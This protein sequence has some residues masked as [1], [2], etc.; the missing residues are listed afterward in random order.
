MDIW[1]NVLSDLKKNY[2]RELHGYYNKQEAEQLL[3]ILIEHFFAITRYE[4]ILKPDYRLSESEIL[5]LHMAVK[6]LKKYKPVQ[7]IT[8]MVEFHDLKFMVN[9][10]VL[11]PRPETEE[12]VQLI[13]NIENKNQHTILDIGTGSGCI[14]ISL[15]KLLSN[16]LVHATDYSKSAL[17]IAEKNSKS[18]NTDVVFYN[19]NI[20]DHQQPITDE[21]RNLIIFDII[22]SNP[23]YVTQV[24]KQKMQ[25][26]VINYEPHN[27]LFVTDDEPLE[28]Y[29]AILNF[30]HNQLKTGGR[31]YFE[32]NESLGKQ[33]ITLLKNNGYTN[34]ELKKDITRRDRFIYG[35][36]S[37][38]V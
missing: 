12:L 18:N 28:Y 31:I 10:D 15:S 32:I 6:Q 2:L 22:V 5:V 11:I 24:D 26:N 19:H 7:Y 38:S 17:T 35:T 37:I 1:N 3:T 8:G 20:L 29:K 14:A 16:P 21:T 30:A 36:K 4:L 9:E 25:P 33:M 34:I 23:P 27:A 13:Y